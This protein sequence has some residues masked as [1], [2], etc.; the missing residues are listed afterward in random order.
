MPY[1]GASLLDAS[2]VVP[3]RERIA[4]LT[5]RGRTSTHVVPAY[6]SY[7]DVACGGGCGRTHRIYM[8]IPCPL[9]LSLARRK[10]ER[11]PDALTSVTVTSVTVNGVSVFGPKPPLV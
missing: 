3:P 8:A 7:I 9:L 1:R 11:R 6:Q 4:V 10:A 2:L 5:C